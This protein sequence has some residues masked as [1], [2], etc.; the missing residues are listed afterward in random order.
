ME[1]DPKDWSWRRVGMLPDTS[2]L[3][4]TTKRGYRTAL[5]QEN[6]QMTIDAELEAS[7][8]DGKARDKF[9][10]KI[11]HPYLPRKVSA[12]QWLLLAE[13]LPVGSW[14]EKVG[15]NGACQLCILQ[16]RETTKHAFLDCEEVK[17]AWELFRNIIAKTNLPPAYHTW[18]EISRGLMTIPSGPSV[19]AEL[20][21]DTASEFS[22]NMETPW[23]I[24][25]AQ[26]LWAIWSQRLSHAFNDERF[27]LGLVI[28]YA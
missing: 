2:V 4:Y 15:L 13:G 8:F 19:E 18:T 26:L 14:R 21:W 1:W 11:W 9:W 7:G 17:Q 3:N 6:H 28:W 5:K 25:R 22:I 12:M 27:H 20:R 23:D 24:L 16:E 10:N